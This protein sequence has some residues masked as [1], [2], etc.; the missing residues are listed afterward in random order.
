MRIVLLLFTLDNPLSLEEI[1]V[2]DFITT[3]GKEFY[4]TDISLNGDSEFKLSKAT[5]RRK[6]VV[7]SILYLVRNGY[8]Y[9]IVLKRETKYKITE[10]GNDLYKKISQTEYSKKYIL[11]VKLGKR[12]LFN[13]KENVLDLI[14]ER[15]N[16]DE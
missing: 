11:T 7:E 14:L 4:L 5:L 12:E 1:F 9:P 6:R 13:K 2:F 3:Y 10:K 15:I 8:I 16:N